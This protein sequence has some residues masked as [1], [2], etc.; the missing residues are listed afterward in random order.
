M[1]FEFSAQAKQQIERILTRYPNKQAALLPVLHIA[2][3][4]FGHLP[5]EVLELVARTLDLP[6]AHVF[7]VVTFYTMFHRQRTGANHLMVC[8]NIS[9]MLRGGNEILHHI[10]KKLG[11]GPGETTSD[12]A[13]TLIE[14]ECLAGCANAPMMV[15]G[16]QYYL[17]LTP[18]KVDVVLDDL[19]GRYEQRKAEAQRGGQGATQA[20]Q[21]PQEVP[22]G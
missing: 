21:A 1:A 4:D 14:E 3:D 13:F 7:G 5:D 17:D 22:P 11:I 12:G 8:T 16:S 2:Q 6:P 10:E 20:P 9:C 18:D 15:C 19:R